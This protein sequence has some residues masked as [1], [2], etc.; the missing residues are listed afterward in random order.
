MENGIDVET[1]DIKRFAEEPC[2]GLP[3]GREVGA[4]QAGVDS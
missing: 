3:G 4:P 2:A 1:F